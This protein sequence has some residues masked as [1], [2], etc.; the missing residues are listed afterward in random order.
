MFD[1]S[2]R[3]I[4]KVM[5]EQSILGIL[6]HLAEGIELPVV[7]SL[8]LL[9]LKLLHPYYETWK[10]NSTKLKEIQSIERIEKM[11]LKAN[12]KKGKPPN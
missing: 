3:Q 11:K 1:L 2:F 6:N 8:I 7:I 9:F 5:E 4:G 10:N 12:G